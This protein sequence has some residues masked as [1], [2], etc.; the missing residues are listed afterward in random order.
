MA[1]AYSQDLRDR[2]IDAALA[3]TPARHAANRFGIGVATA[4]RWVRQARETGKR[5]PDRQGSPRRS[6]LDP[7]CEFILGLVEKTPDMTISEMLECLAAEHGVRACRATLWKFLDRNGLTFKKSRHMRA[8][9]T[10]P[11]L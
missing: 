6:K 3:G 9:R 8:N 10:V 4:I 11:T 7:H 5:T 1:R 2:I